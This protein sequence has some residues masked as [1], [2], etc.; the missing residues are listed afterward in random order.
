MLTYP[1]GQVNYGVLGS[2]DKGAFL[3]MG[4]Q[5][6]DAKDIAKTGVTAVANSPEI[7][8]RLLDLG[9]SA[10]PTAQ[11]ATVTVSVAPETK[12][13]MK[14]AADKQGR[15]VSRFVEEIV[16]EWLDKNSK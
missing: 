10:R 14:A 8:K 12:D 11:Q 1:D 16:N 6:W 5:R 15:S 2:D 13:R 3:M 7:L 9:F 4:S